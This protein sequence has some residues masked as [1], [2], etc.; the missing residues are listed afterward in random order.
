MQRPTLAV[1]ALATPRDRTVDPKT[2]ADVQSSMAIRWCLFQARKYG[3][4][5]FRRLNY[6]LGGAIFVHGHWLTRPKPH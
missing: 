4:S 1:G 2:V 6:R 5:A 3:W